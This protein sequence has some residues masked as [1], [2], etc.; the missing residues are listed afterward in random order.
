[1][2]KL[3]GDEKIFYENQIGPRLRGFR[4]SQE[5]DMNYVKEQELAEKERQKNAACH[6]ET[7]QETDEDEKI[8]QDVSDLMNSSMSRSGKVHALTEDFA[9]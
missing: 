1:M 8:M 2:D 9:A 3:E 4:L 7:I 6:H 5:I